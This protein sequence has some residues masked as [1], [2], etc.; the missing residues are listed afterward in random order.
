MRLNSFECTRF[1]R[2][3]SIDLADRTALVSAARGS[4]HRAVRGLLRAARGPSRRRRG[5]Q[6]ARAPHERSAHGRTA[7]R[8]R[9]ALLSV[10]RLCVS[11]SGQRLPPA[12]RRC[13][14]AALRSLLRPH[15]ALRRRRHLRLLLLVSRV[16]PARALCLPSYQRAARRLR[17]RRLGT[18]EHTGGGDRRSGHSGRRSVRGGGRRGGRGRD[19]DMRGTRGKHR[20]RRSICALADGAARPVRCHG[21]HH[22]RGGVGRPRPI[23]QC[24]Q[25]PHLRLPRLS[26][27]AELGP[28]RGLLIWP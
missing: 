5:L 1:N 26:T 12:A 7:R 24:L 25:A 19:G 15:V 13:V 23:R 20:E 18:G 6:V 8:A 3:H 27:R 14:P 17:G 22:V 10:D 2:L 9:G 16:V 11:R 21:T 4:A 28:I